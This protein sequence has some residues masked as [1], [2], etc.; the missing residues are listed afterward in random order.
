M[1]ALKQQHFP[2]C[3]L[4]NLQSISHEQLKLIL[5]VTFPDHFLQS[6]NGSNNDVSRVKA[7]STAKE[8]KG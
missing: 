4:S 5:V 6:G 8:N 2:S 1:Q 3:F 7:T